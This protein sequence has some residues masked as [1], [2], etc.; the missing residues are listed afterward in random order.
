MGDEHKAL[1]LIN[2]GTGES[3]KDETHMGLR[4][5]LLGCWRDLEIN[6]E[7]EDFKRNFDAYTFHD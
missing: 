1:V 5:G 6:V 3:I 4:I 2:L 7:I